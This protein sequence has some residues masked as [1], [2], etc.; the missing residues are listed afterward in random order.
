MEMLVTF[1]GGARVDATF[2][3]NQCAVKKHLESPPSF[4]VRTVVK[5]PE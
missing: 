3:A 4:E 2:G 1:P 5:Q